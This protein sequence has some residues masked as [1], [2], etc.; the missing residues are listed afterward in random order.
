MEMD[1]N[2]YL[3]LNGDTKSREQQYYADLCD[4]AFKQ[5]RYDDY[6]LASKKIAEFRLLDKEYQEAWE[7]YRDMAHLYF[8]WENNPN[9]ALS[10]YWKI[11]DIKKKAKSE[12]YLPEDSFDFGDEMFEYY[13]DESHELSQITFCLYQMEKY[14]ELL[15]HQKTY[16]YVDHEKDLESLVFQ[17]QAYSKLGK[18][19][20]AEN[21]WNNLGKDSLTGIEKLEEDYSIFTNKKEIICF[22]ECKKYL[23]SKMS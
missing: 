14:E 11:I 12:K 17:G 20:E 19:N 6:F 7:D 8:Y 1:I 22:S 18:I 16:A 5:K 2:S 4:Q 13:Y 10:A 15:L 3:D 23:S 9:K 21:I